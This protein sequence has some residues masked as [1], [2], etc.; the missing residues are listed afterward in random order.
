MNNKNYSILLLLGLV[1][2]I[3]EL[4]SE[5][6]MIW[7]TEGPWEKLL[8]PM[9]VVAISSYILLF[10]F[11]LACIITGLL[12]AD[13][14]NRRARKLG[15]SSGIRWLMIAG[16]LLVPAYIY[17]Y[18]TWQTV[19]SHPW[20]QL[21]VAMG[22]AQLILF[23]A[24]PQR[25][26]QFGWSEFSL[27][28][29]LFL[30]SRVVQEIR[31][32]FSNTI[33]SRLATATGLVILLLFIFALYSTYGRRLRS[34]LIV[35]REKLGFVRF[36]LIALLCLTP[37]FYRYMV[38]LETYIIYDDIRFA[39]LLVAVWMA[40]Y[41]GITG[42][43]DLVSLEALGLSLGTLMFTSFL[44]QYSLLVINYPFSLSWSEGDRFYDY[45]LVFGQSVY[46]YNGHISDPYS[47]PGRYGLWG[48]LFMWPGL[49]IWV[50]R[51]WNL[52][53]QTLPVL[54]FSELITRKLTPPALRYGVLIW[55]ALFLTLLAPLHPPFVIASLMAIAFAFDESLI[56]RG[57]SLVVASLY[58]GLSRWTW[59]FAPAALGMLID[60]ML[61]SLYFGIA[62]FQMIYWVSV[63]SF[64]R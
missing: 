50:H 5:T 46:H 55:I 17:L 64:W 53:L 25:E 29:S 18:S 40:A 12:R 32:L 26:Q 47:S 30:Y 8:S 22:V 58:A 49:P 45:S 62:F 27:A 59:A 6:S 16:L 19:L 61:Y 20:T 41:L 28:L 10:L 38:G 1:V 23:I 35:W 63:F 9:G 60:L 21:I 57:F 33:A 14:L 13:V 43:A 51:L 54:I 44:A 11:G 7:S 4:W 37:I 42:S 15:I 31:A 24:A 39:V 56:K 34:L 2:G 48:V 52:I 3:L 36:V